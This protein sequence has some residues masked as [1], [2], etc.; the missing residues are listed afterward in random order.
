MTNY[1]AVITLILLLL[2]NPCCKNEEVMAICFQPC[3]KNE[4]CTNSACPMCSISWNACVSYAAHD[5]DR[6]EP[7]EAIMDRDN[8]NTNG[9]VK[10]FWQY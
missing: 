1:S 4:D 2:Q 6:E 10:E 7:Q 9:E 5:Q 8:Y 3:T